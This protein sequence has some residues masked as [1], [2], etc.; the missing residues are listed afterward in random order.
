MKMLAEARNGA[1]MLV[2][3]APNL[4][5]DA[6]V[7]RILRDDGAQAAVVASMSAFRTIVDE[8]HTQYFKKSKTLPMYLK[9]IPVRSQRRYTIPTCGHACRLRA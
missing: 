2:Y 4:A 1:S 7:A 9:L 5:D 3:L 8:H 6:V